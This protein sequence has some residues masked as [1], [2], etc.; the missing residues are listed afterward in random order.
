VAIFCEKAILIYISSYLLYPYLMDEIILFLSGI[1]PLSPE[2]IA[3]LKRA[4]RKR[5]V[6]KDQII[7]EIGE[8]CQNLYFIK[9]G[10]LRCFYFVGEKE[11]SD[12]FFWEGETVVSIE[13]FYD[14]AGSEDC[15]Q[16]LEDCELYYISFQELEYLYQHYIEFNIIGRVLTIKY[17]R[18]FHQHAR[19][20]RK[21]SAAD[22]YHY[23]LRTQPDL[24]QRIPL[25]PLA[26]WLNREPETLSRMRARRNN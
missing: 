23:L 20:I 8:V 22:R 7:L 6:K 16:A 21:L 18:V 17:L 15:I 11:V 14:Q 26:S 25:G 4:I 9:K 1:Y 13:S 5:M 19:N 3:Y 10:V 2:C 24:V 12:W